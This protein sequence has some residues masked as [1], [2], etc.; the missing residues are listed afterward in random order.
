M[1]Q[2]TTKIWK[3][4]SDHVSMIQFEFL[5][6]SNVYY[7]PD[8]NEWSGIDKHYEEMSLPNVYAILSRHG[9]LKEVETMSIDYTSEVSKKTYK[10]SV[11]PDKKRID[12]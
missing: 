12:E 6:G 2:Y 9:L 3:E 4:N 7:F 8:R 1:N 10:E 11:T 5:N